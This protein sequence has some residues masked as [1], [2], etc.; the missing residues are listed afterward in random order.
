MLFFVTIPSFYSTKQHRLL[1][2]PPSPTSSGGCTVNG[3]TNTACQNMST[4]PPSLPPSTREREV[5]SPKRHESFS[6]DLCYMWR[7]ESITTLPVSA[8]CSSGSFP[9]TSPSVLNLYRETIGT[10][11]QIPWWHAQAGRNGR[12]GG[13]ARGGGAFD[14]WGVFHE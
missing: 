6:V 1:P 8:I 3:V 9:P 2:P 13:R 14:F 10:R 11:V 5:S 4:H 12:A 7:F